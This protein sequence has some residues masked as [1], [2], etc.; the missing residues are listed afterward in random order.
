MNWPVLDFQIEM[1]E[2]KNWK[3][4]EKFQTIS[5]SCWHF[6]ERPHYFVQPSM[7]TVGKFDLF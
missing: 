1:S 7:L 2:K 4:T 6:E 3:T 5:K